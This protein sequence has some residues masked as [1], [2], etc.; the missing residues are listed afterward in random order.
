[1][2]TQP[3]LNPEMRAILID[4]LVEVQVKGGCGGCVSLCVGEE[5]TL[6]LTLASRLSRSAVCPFFPPPAFRARAGEL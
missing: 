4:W 6:F 1:M 5:R 2:S 3:S